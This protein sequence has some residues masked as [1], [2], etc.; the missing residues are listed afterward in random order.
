MEEFGNSLKETNQNLWKHD[1]NLFYKYFLSTLLLL[2]YFLLYD[3]T[4]PK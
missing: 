4:F 2:E 1:P 3:D